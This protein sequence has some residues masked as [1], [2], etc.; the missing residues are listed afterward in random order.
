[1][2]LLHRWSICWWGVVRGRRN[3]H[4]CRPAACSKLSVVAISCRWSVE[5]LGERIN[6]DKVKNSREGILL[7]S[8]GN[9]MIELALRRHVQLILS[10]FKKKAWTAAKSHRCFKDPFTCASNRWDD[11]SSASEFCLRFIYFL[12]CSQSDD[13][14][15]QSP[16][17]DHHPGRPGWY[18]AWWYNIGLEPPKR[19]L[20]FFKP[21][22]A[23]V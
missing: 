5:E 6:S 20:G 19:F 16:R 13:H 10:S 3:K 21:T 12:V 1:M 11:S 2:V 4:K 15:H 17:H 22:G 23:G 7:R 14:D 8:I 18:I 9:K